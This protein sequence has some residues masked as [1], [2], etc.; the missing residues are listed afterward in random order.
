VAA[1]VACV[2]AAAPAHAQTAPSPTP[3]GQPPL[4][5]EPPVPL[6]SASPTA[7]PTATATA[8]PTATAT[9]SATPT[10]TESAPATPADGEELARTGS[11]AGLL[12]LAGASLLGMGI[13]LRRLV[14][15][16]GER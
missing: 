7:T 12:A 15:A 8:T 11:D 9:V 1:L 16:H 3:G 6:G 13:G 14:P 2:L 4:T 5:G 10:A